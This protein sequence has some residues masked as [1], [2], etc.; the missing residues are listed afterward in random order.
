MSAKIEQKTE[1]RQF[2]P[3]SFFPL[4]H[5]NKQ[6]FDWNIKPKPYIAKTTAFPLNQMRSN[7][8]FAKDL[9]ESKFSILQIN[10]KKFRGKKSSSRSQDT[11]FGKCN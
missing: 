2:L 8:E 4:I 3:G 7:M 11:C 10:K 1:L 5:T 9:L 6:W